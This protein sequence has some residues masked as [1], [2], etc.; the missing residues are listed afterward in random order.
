MSTFPASISLSTSTYFPIVAEVTPNSS[1]LTFSTFC[2]CMYSRGLTTTTDVLK[3]PEGCNF[4]HPDFWTL[5]PN[6]VGRTTKTSSFKQTILWMHSLCS[7]FNDLWMKSS[8]DELRAVKNSQFAS[9]SAAAII[10]KLHQKSNM[11]S[12]NQ[13]ERGPKI[14]FVFRPIGE[15]N[16]LWILNM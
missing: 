3:P 16:R 13:L 14:F 15:K 2:F 4:F 7:S 11:Q 12:C 1:F 10:L 8:R 6:A 9:S 5:L